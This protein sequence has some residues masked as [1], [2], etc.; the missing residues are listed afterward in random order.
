MGHGSFLQDV[1]EGRRSEGQSAKK[2]PARDGA[3][4]P[5]LRA[6]QRGRWEGRE[7]NAAQAAG[8]PPRGSVERVGRLGRR[9]LV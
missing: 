4:P 3:R 7:T 5:T 8:R 2:K 6:A 9:S 1:G